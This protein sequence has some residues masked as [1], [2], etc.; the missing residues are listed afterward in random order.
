MPDPT[1]VNTEQLDRMLGQVKPLES[2]DF[3]PLMEDWRAILERDNED[4]LGIDGYGIPMEAVTYRPDAKAGS[5]KPIRYDILAN[6]NLTS[7]HYRTLDGPP[8]SPRGSDSR[9][10]QNFRTR[11]ERDEPNQ[12]EWTTFAGWE[13]FIS[14]DSEEI[15]PFHAAGTEHN[16]RLPIRDLLNI[17]PSAL[18]KARDALVGFVN[19]LL[20][21]LG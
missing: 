6:N 20:G 9:V 18:A 5:R 21:R 15:L 2:I 10:T 1:I 8:L 13:D 11:W 14:L 17:R 3:A 19:K 7:G 16:P 12:G 4:N